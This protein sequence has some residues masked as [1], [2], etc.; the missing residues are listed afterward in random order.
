MMHRFAK[1]KFQ[2]KIVKYFLTHNFSICFGCPKEPSHCFGWEIRLFS[3][4][5]SKLKI[6]KGNY[7]LSALGHT[8]ELE[9]FCSFD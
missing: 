5:H 9:E 4:M 2:R 6:Y 3:A 7:E 1:Q 8:Y